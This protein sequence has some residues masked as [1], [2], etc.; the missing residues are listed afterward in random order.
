MQYISLF[1]SI[2]VGIDD[3]RLQYRSIMLGH[4]LRDTIRILYIFLRVS[5]RFGWDATH[6]SWDPAFFWGSV[7]AGRDT[8]NQGP[9]R[10]QGYQAIQRLWFTQ[11]VWM[12][13][14]R[15]ISN[16]PHHPH[17][18]HLMVAIVIRKLYVWYLK[19]IM[20]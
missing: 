3:D 7:P 8:Q 10:A 15:T 2:T 6:P 4:F 20:L 1:M 12:S 11:S 17:I 13:K 16:H 18:Q 9:G 5:W 14:I 19:T